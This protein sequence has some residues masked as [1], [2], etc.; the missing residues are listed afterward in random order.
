MLHMM[1][2]RPVMLGAVLL[3]VVMAMAQSQPEREALSVQGYPGQAR[4]HLINGPRR[5]GLFPSGAK[6]L[7]FGALCGTAK[8]LAEKVFSVPECHLS[9]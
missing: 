4:S 7:V 6:A 9:G 8:Q 2:H 3:M 1:K 5:E